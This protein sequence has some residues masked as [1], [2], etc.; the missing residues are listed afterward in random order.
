M[1]KRLYD[2]A[3]DYAK[4]VDPASVA[5]EGEV[6]AAQKYLLP[7]KGLG[8][9]NST[10]KKYIQ[11]MRD[12]L[13]GRMTAKNSNRKNTQGSAGMGGGAGGFPRTVTDAQ[14]RTATVSSEAEL[15]EA[16]AEGFK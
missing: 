1:D 16:Q 10:A 4:I 14:G 8:V 3:L 6:A 2:I 15:K 12:T 5:R 7:I 9:R 11:D 13:S